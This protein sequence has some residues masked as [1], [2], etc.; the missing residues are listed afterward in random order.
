M[1]WFPDK[2]TNAVGTFLL[3]K[4]GVRAYM[5]FLL[6]NSIVKVLAG[7]NRGLVVWLTGI[8]TLTMAA[9]NHKGS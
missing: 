4:H 7:S 5:N 2:S 6:H 1:P 8:R 9:H 3:A